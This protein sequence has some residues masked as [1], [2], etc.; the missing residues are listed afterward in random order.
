MGDSDFL[1]GMTTPQGI[2]TSIGLIPQSVD[3]PDNTVVEVGVRADDIDFRLHPSGNGTITQRIFSGPFYIYRIKL[4]SG[5]TLNAFKLHTEVYSISTR[6][7][8]TVNA[9]HP[10]PVFRN[11]E[12][13]T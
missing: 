12:S 2:H 13:T 1:N 7:N 9:G 4:D 6:V 8:V 10:L 3:L 11:G 5:Q